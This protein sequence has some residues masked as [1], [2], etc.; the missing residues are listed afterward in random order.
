MFLILL[1]VGFSLAVLLAAGT[2]FIQGYIYSEP[3][4]EIFWRAPAAAAV[5]T[6]FL[7]FW[8]FLNYRAADPK[9]KELP[10]E[11]LFTSAGTEDASDAKAELWVERAG[12]R[13]HYRV[14]KYE[15]TPPTFE[16]RV[17]GKPLKPEDKSIAAVIVKEGDPKE[18]VEVRFVARHDEKKYVE[19]GGSRYMTFA[20]FGR[21]YTPRPGRST[22]MLI[23]NIVH[24]AV[25]F[26]VVWLLLRFQWSHALGLA[27]VFWLAMT[28][29]F[30]PLILGKLK[31]Q[32]ARRASEGRPSLARRSSEQELRA[33]SSSPRCA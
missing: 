9:A 5:L 28:W 13:T 32:L 19:E 14:Y 25:W 33:F 20:N 6:A 30:V 7:G 10:Y 24:L 31:D 27:V 29:L 18:S 21:L 12:G 2:L 8:C 3:A 23:I 17:E 16:Y 1:V 11:T 4:G 15:G 22:V 26:L